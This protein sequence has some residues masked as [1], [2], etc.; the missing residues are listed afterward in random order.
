VGTLHVRPVLDMRRDGAAKMRAIAEEACALVKQYKGAYSGEHG[1]GLVR[2]EW[3]APFF[4]PRLTAALGEIK[5]WLDPK[6]LMNPGKI[7][8][9]SKMDDKALFR[10]KPGYEATVPAPALDWSE[11]GGLDKAVEMC[12]NNGHCRKFDAGTMCPSYRV[13]RD[14]QHLTRGRANTLRLALSGQLGPDAFTGGAMYETMDLC[15]GCKG[16]K[17]ECPTG[18]DVARM[19]IEFLAHYKARHGHT[20]KDLLIAHFPDYARAASRVPWLMNLRD[21]LPGAAWASER[22][23]GLSAR[24]RLPEWRRDTFWRAADAS[25]FAGTDATIAAAAAGGKAAVLFVDT[26]N[27]TF[28]SENALAAASVL[29]VA[30]YTLHTVGKGD[31]H[32]CCGRTYLAC[33]MVEQAKEKAG[34]LIDALLPMAEA[35]VAIVGLEPSCLLTLRDEALVMG[36]GP[37]AEI[38]SS[39]AL[40]F[41]EFVAREAKAGRFALDLKA[42]GAPILLHGHCHQ[43]AFGAVAPILDVLRLIPDAK[44]ELIESSC[45]GMAGSFGYEANHYDLSMQMAEASLLPALRRQPDAIVVADGT[46]CRH[47]IADGAGREAVHVARLLERLLPAS[48]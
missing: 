5:S 42:A 40:L 10:F 11:W 39:Q 34:A 28:E 22:L 32:H 29:Q 44:P 38:V 31:G 1:D 6:G 36:L 16:C 23:L 8:A 30:G 45:G 14:E 12:N 27:G 46:S 21:K 7:V 17:R 3:I 20:L 26:F 15:V 41:E 24:R 2:S 47:Q 13:T 25:M 4:G 48:L 33:G 37:R 35:G 9:P 43:K 18:V 19:K